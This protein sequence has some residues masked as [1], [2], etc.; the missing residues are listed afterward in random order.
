MSFKTIVNIQRL[1]NY[2]KKK[3]RSVLNVYWLLG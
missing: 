2:I 1:L 3:A